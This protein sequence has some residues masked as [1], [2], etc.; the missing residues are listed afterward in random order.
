MENSGIP[1]TFVGY[2]RSDK[3]TTYDNFW[4]SEEFSLLNLEGQL[5]KELR[6]LVAKAFYQDLCKACSIH[7][8]EI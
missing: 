6:G 3:Y 8:N 4:K 1:L 5:H 7:G 2:K